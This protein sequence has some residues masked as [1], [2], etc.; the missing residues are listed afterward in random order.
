MLMP[1]MGTRDVDAQTGPEAG[2][3][4]SQLTPVPRA[5]AHAHVT[6]AREMRMLATR[7]S[8]HTRHVKLSMAAE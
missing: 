8:K 5:A 2:L 3:D 1:A 4:T 6:A 7:G